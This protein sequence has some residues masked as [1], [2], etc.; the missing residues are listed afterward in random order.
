M[1]NLFGDIP[2]HLES[3]RGATEK[4]KKKP[5][6]AEAAS[7]VFPRLMGRVDYARGQK[8]V[9][10]GGGPGL[11]AVGVKALMKLLG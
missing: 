2:T 6:Y 8:P 4:K 5:P 1:P 7:A 10:P 11:A 9:N 3:V